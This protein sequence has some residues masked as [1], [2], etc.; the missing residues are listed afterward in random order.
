MTMN[1]IDLV[2]AIRDADSALVTRATK[3]V[4]VSLTLRNWLI[5]HYVSEYELSGADRA[6]YGKRILAELADRL[7]G[8][9]NCSKRQLSKYVRFYR[10]YPQIGGTSYT[11]FEKLLPDN[12][13][14]KDGFLSIAISEKQIEGTASTQF[15]ADLIEQ[16]SYSHLEKLSEIDDETKRDFYLVECLGGGWTVKELKR[17]IGSLY[18]ERSGLSHNKEK[19]AKLT[20]Q[21]SEHALKPFNIRDPYVFEFLGLKAKEIMSESHLKG[22]LVD[23]LEDFVLELGQGFCLEAREK[24]IL[25]GGEHFFVDIVFYHRILKCHVLI[26]VKIETFTHESVGQLNT[27]VSWYQKNMMTESDNPPIGILLC[28]GKNESLVEYALAGMDNNLFVSKYMLELPRTEDMR[29]F[30]E[31]QMKELD[32][33]SEKG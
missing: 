33:E 14:Q 6:D 29:A 13:N 25:I 11:Q 7:D 30:I 22:Q 32:F 27:Y 18:Y 9:S 21:H 3:A 15:G 31:Q 23:K 24:R 16:L 5:G 1:F 20:R 19:L 4:N 12:K 2:E 28:T 26:E 10:V 8:V 17:Q